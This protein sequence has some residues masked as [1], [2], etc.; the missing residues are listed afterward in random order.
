MKAFVITIRGL[1]LSELGAQQCVKAGAKF[2]VGIEVF[3][4]TNR[5][6]AQAELQAL[7]LDINREKYNAIS[8]API[9]DRDRTPK[10]QWHLTTPEL[11]CFLSHHRLWTVCVELDEPV[12]IFEH[13]TQLIATVP[14]LPPILHAINLNDTEATSTCGYI[15]SPVGAHALIAEAAE[16][17]AQPS[18]EMLWRTAIPLSRTAFCNPAVIAIDDGGVST[19]QYSR[20]DARHDSVRKT[21]PWR[22]FQMRDGN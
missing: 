21:D 16:H 12:L 1:P 8:D 18:D 17:G 15:I 5:Y 6:Q 13:D 3:A 11:G 19:I 2:G 10:G 14:G 7:G 22:S 4:A 20:T 9:E